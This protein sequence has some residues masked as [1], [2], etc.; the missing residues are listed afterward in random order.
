MSWR[1]A[2]HDPRITVIEN[3]RRMGQSG[4][5]VQLLSRPEIDDEDIIVDVDG[6]DILP[7]P[8][9]LQRVLNAYAD[10]RAWMTWGSFE[11]EA[12]PGGQIM[13][14]CAAPIDVDNIRTEPWHLSHLRTFKAFLFRAIKDEDLRDPETGWYHL[15]GADCPTFF[16]MAEL[17]GCGHARYLKEK[18]YWYNN[19][20]PQ[21]EWRTHGQQ[22]TRTE[23]L[24]RAM[25]RYERLERP[26]SG[27]G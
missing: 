6:D 8:G 7:D 25:P 5:H 20:N 13:R 4:N 9:V 2:S 11:F 19:T 26:C 17:A 24:V 16:P 21:N 3:E 18:N 14:G 12:S 15:A 10:G 1:W 22:Q 23:M 27:V